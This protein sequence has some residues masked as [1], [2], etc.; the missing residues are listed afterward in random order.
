LGLDNFQ[1]NVVVHV[2][3]EGIILALKSAVSNASKYFAIEYNCVFAVDEDLNTNSEFKKSITSSEVQTPNSYNPDSNMAITPSN[4]IHW[5][6]AKVFRSL[7]L[8]D[9][10]LFVRATRECGV[11]SGEE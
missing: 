10:P 7:Q 11:H 3:L 6:A 9:N 4:W 2:A 5:N 1:T 8:R